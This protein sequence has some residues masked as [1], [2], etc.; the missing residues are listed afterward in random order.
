MI[1]GILF[2]LAVIVAIIQDF[3]EPEQIV[4]TGNMG[5]AFEQPGNWSSRRVPQPTD[6]VYVLFGSPKDLTING[7]ITLK[8]FYVQNGWAGVMTLK[9]DL[10]ITGNLSINE[11]MLMCGDRAL[12][13]SGTGTLSGPTFK[14]S[15]KATITTNNKLWKQ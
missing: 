2:I 15:E 10:T 11:R 6:E 13:M 4:F 5:N 7:P 14:A 12:I 8:N 3:T 9:G 1:I